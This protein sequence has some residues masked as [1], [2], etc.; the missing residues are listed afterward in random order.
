MAVS[1]LF[2]DSR[3]RSYMRAKFLLE[4]DA[5]GKEGA[6]QYIVNNQDKATKI[7]KDNIRM[8]KSNL[9]SLIPINVNDT[10]YVFNIPDNL[11]NQGNQNGILPL[12]KRLSIQDVFFC[13]ALGFFLTCYSANGY[14]AI[15]YQFWTYPTPSLGGI[16]GLNDV[17]A[18]AGIWTSGN[19]EIKTNGVIQ[20]PN[21]W[22]WNH[23]SV[24]QTQSNFSGTPVNPFWDQQSMSEDG[25]QVTEPNLIING[26]NKNLYTVMYDNTWAQVL[27]GA[28]AGNTYQFAL[29]MVWDGW[30]AQNASS[31]MNNQP[32][33]FK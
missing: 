26:G 30:L 12:E 27:G 16:L 24:P 33:K 20:T 18:L 3:N 22:L 10:N 2:L 29:A 8:A 14:Q 11:P 31:I 9:V 5:D 32:A 25:F 21:W 13:N 7:G 17:A 15:H 28:N 4:S 1:Q 6:G 19:L 23:Q